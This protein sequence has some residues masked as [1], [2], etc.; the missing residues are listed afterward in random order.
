MPTMHDLTRVAA[1]AI[2]SLKTVRRV[3]QGRGNEYSRRRVTEAAKALG[4]PVPPEPQ[5]R[6]A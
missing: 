2:V 4:L 6:A 5:H 3:Y 1:T